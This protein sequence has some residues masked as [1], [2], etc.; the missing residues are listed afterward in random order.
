MN[1]SR[2]VTD[3]YKT[4]E[5]EGKKLNIG[6][7]FIV[8]TVTYLPRLLRDHC[9]S[10]CPMSPL[11]HLPLFTFRNVDKNCFAK[12]ALVIH[13]SPSDQNTHVLITRK[14][15]RQK[16]DNAPGMEYP[17]DG[18]RKKTSAPNLVVASI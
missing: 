2:C 9:D 16:N 5:N 8:H 4:D 6:G 12:N 14:L 17:H 13:P 11:L 7:F 1:E 3:V 10:S 15:A 18:K